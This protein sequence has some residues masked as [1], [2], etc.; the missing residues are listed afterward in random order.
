MKTAVNLL[1]EISTALGVTVCVENAFRLQSKIQNKS[2]KIIAVLKNYVNKKNLMEM[3]R[4]KKLKAK[5]VN[6]KWKD[7]SIFINHYL[8][9]TSSNLFYKTRRYAKEH[10]YKYIWLRDCKLF[11][12]K[13][14]TNKVI[15]T[16]DE[17]SLLRLE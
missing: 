8:T 4:K 7:E 9:Q 17:N 2:G 11:I 1:N 6:L 16:E 10:N 5:N 15:L 12:R 14:E 13:D 3:T